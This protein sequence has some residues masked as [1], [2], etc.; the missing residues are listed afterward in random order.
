M[1][2][3]IIASGLDS[4]ELHGVFDKCGFV[5]DKDVF[6]NDIVVSARNGVYEVL[7]GIYDTGIAPQFL[8]DVNH[9]QAV[10][11]VGQIHLANRAI[12]K[13]LCCPAIGRL[14]AKLTGANSVTLWGSQLYFKPSAQNAACQIGCH[15]DSQHLPGIT[16]GGL[17][18]WIPLTSTHRECGTLTYLIGSHKT[19]TLMQMSGAQD[20]DIDSQLQLFRHR[21]GQ[22][23]YP[24][25]PLNLSPGDLSIHHQDT[26]HFSQC[27]V[28]LKPRIAIGISIVTDKTT[29]SW[30]DD[31]YGIRHMLNDPH[32]CHKYNL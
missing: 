3:N 23:S 25:Y 26:I 16:D 15:R 22:D 19:T 29:Y 4:N 1:A 2:N 31:S 10:N 7:E 13:L 30:T 8:V 17:Y 21:F 18:A 20:P 5:I 12:A 6:T 14:I 32:W 24:Q 28:R 9:P 27:N 11:R